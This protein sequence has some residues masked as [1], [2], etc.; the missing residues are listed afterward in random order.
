MDP[1]AG[2]S[3]D[4]GSTITLSLSTETTTTQTTAA[5]VAKVTVPDVI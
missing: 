4:K 2:T 1:D 3:I 5:T